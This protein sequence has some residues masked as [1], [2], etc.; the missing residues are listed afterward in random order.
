MDKR[1]IDIALEWAGNRGWLKGEFARELE[2]Y[3]QLTDPEARVSG[4]SISN[5]I[6]RGMPAEWLLPT[7]RLF[8]K[9]VEE[10]TGEAPVKPPVAMTSH[11][12]VE[13]VEPRSRVPL[14]SW[15]KAGVLTTIEDVF[16]PGDADEWIET[17]APT[18]PRTFAL[19]ITG[20]SMTNPHG[21][22]SFPEGCIIIVDPDRAPTVGAYVVAKD[23]TTH[24][25]TFKRLA[26]DAGRWFLRPLNPQYPTLEIDSPELRVIGV[27]VE[28]TFT[29]KL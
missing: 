22:P 7:A 14:I 12:N 4:A 1:P 24:E 3:A 25:A 20:D 17:S 8:G 15:I 16:H 9:T 6:K 11:R 2:A 10:L 13:P 27:A 5:W 18:G 23:V 21:E 29:R 28:M 26:H 19:R